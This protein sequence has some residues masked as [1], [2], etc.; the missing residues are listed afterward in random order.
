MS[1]ED[2]LSCPQKRKKTIHPGRKQTAITL[3][4][5]ENTDNVK[6]M[7]QNKNAECNL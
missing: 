5:P 1:F 6:R 7:E 4:C 3:N 2:F